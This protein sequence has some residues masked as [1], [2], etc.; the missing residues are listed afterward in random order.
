[1]SKA[2]ILTDDGLVCLAN[3][4]RFFIQRTVYLDRPNIYVLWHLPAT[5]VKARSVFGRHLTMFDTLIGCVHRALAVQESSIIDREYYSQWRNSRLL[6]FES[7][8]IIDRFCC[9]VHLRIEVLQMVITSSYQILHSPDDLQT[10]F[11][12]SL[13]RWSWRKNWF[14]EETCKQK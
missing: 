5:F 13:R 6:L 12:C 8:L 14:S 4:T 11:K 10:V 2:T 1:M 3:A 7:R 9:V